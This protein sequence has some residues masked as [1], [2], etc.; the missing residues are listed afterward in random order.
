MSQTINN[1]VMIGESRML[2]DILIPVYRYVVV[3]PTFCARFL[4]MVP[5]T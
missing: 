5:T 3:H 4:V 2:L 1:R